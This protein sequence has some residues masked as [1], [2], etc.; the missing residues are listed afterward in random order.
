M[1]VDYGDGKQKSR[2]SHDG[3]MEAVGLLPNQTITITLNFAREH[4][5]APVALALLDGGALGAQPTTT[6]PAN[7]KLTF[8]FAA[9]AAP[10]LYRVVVTS[11]EK[12]QLNLYVVRPTASSAQ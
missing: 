3:D 5:G 11:L 4:A 10:G 1:V 2:I 6:L 7:G 8:T 9:P 12:Y